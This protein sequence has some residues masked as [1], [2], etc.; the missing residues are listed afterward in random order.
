VALVLKVEKGEL[1][2]IGSDIT[3]HFHARCGRRISLA[4]A[5]P[6]DVPIHRRGNDNALGDSGSEK[7]DKDK[8]TR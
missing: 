2:T 5:A 4:I 6:L 3:V 7:R 8:N 1:V